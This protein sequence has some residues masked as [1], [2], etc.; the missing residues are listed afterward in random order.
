MTPNQVA[1]DRHDPLLIVIGP[2]GSGKSAAVRE[3]HRR[4]V[5]TITST[6]TTRPSRDDERNGSIEHRF[7]S[8]ARFTSMEGAGAFLGT[9]TMFGLP[10]RYGL[11]PVHRP[12]GSAIA[13]VMLRAN[14][15]PLVGEHYAN[16]VVYQIEDTPTRSELRVIARSDPA[17]G[18]R[19]LH[20]EEER[21]I[22]QASARRVFVNSSTVDEL[23]EQ[24]AAAIASDVP[25]LVGAGRMRYL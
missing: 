12:S 17:I 15:L 21:R 8:E 19:V 10:Y 22:G 24:I 5:I 16:T 23:L 2:S 7:V 3:L 25:R 1:I 11:P 13:A 6:W 20:Q 9:A 14:L 4:R 18:S